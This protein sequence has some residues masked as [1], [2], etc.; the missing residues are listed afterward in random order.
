MASYLDKDGLEYL[1]NKIKPWIPTKTSDITNDSGYITSGDIPSKTSDLV[2]DSGFITG[3]TETD[4]TVPAWAK[5]STKPSYTASEVGAAEA[6]HTHDDRYYTETEADTLLGG[7]V[8]K[9]GDTMTGDLILEKSS[10]IA[11]NKP[12]QLIFRTVQTDNNITTS[13][14]IRAYDDHDAYNYGTNMVIQSNG[15]MVIGSGE[16]PT[17]VY[18]TLI[19]GTAS[20]DDEYTYITS[21]QAIYFDSACNTIANRKRVAI[22]TSGNVDIQSGGS[23]TKSGTKIHNNITQIT[24]TYKATTANTWEY[25]GKSFTVPSGHMYLVKLQ[26]G[27]A[28]GKPIGVGVHTSTNVSGFPSWHFADSEGVYNA[29]VF[30]LYAGTYYLFEKRATVPSLTNTYWINAIDFLLSS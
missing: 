18:N 14:F 8:S 24:G 1:W 2:N 12:A 27:W 25:T 30:L 17:N 5:E 16:S 26:L 9:A 22:D 28:S 4:P 7:K 19:N 29:P 6:S 20:D 15:N 10:S 11:D 3:Y 21:D 23:F 13:G